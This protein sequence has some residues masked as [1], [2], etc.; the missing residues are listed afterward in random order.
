MNKGQLVILSKMA[1]TGAQ[2]S[3]TELC[4]VESRHLHWKLIMKYFCECLNVESV[5][6]EGKERE[7][8]KMNEG[9]S[10]FEL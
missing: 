3:L 7:T 10:I 4:D 2:G 9:K 8:E 5:N 6:W 1:H